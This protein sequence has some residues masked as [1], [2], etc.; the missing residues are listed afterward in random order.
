MPPALAGGCP[1]YLDVDYTTA[2]GGSPPQITL[3][4]KKGNAMQ[5]T[6]PDKEQVKAPTSA[7][8]GNGTVWPMSQ[9]PNSQAGPVVWSRIAGTSVKFMRTVLDANDFRRNA[10][11]LSQERSTKNA[12]D[13]L[14]LL[15][16]ARAQEREPCPDPLLWSLRIGAADRAATSSSFDLQPSNIL[17]AR[18]SLQARFTETSLAYRSMA[19]WACGLCSPQLEIGEI[20]VQVRDQVR[21]NRPCCF[22]LPETASW[23]AWVGA[24]YGIHIKIPSST[25]RTILHHRY[26]WREISNPPDTREILAEALRYSRLKEAER[27]IGGKAPSAHRRS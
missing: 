16:Q 13:F 18:G 24:S 21:D 11:G 9:L 15:A 6:H 7:P 8:M 14:K 5:R 26:R 1:T 19:V 2:D 3:G 20:C 27:N 10:V 12:Q 25:I 23:I 4:E 22:P 17:A